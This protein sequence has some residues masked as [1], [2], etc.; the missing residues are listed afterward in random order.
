MC[1][2][3]YGGMEM[4]ELPEIRNLAGQIDGALRGAVIVGT[5][6]FQPKCLN[7]PAEEWTKLICGRK[8]LDARSRG[9]WCV[10]G[11]EGTV[12]LRL[13]L[14]MG[15][16]FLLH[17]ADEEMPEKR[18]LA[19]F[20][21]D[22]RRISV[23]FWWF[24]SLHAVAEDE[25]HSEFDRMGVD[26]LDPELDEASF[27]E[28]YAGRKAAIKTL[29]L[30]QKLICGI[31]NYY[32]HDILFRAGIHP[33]KKADMITQEEYGRLYDA[34]RYTFIRA[35]EMGGADYERD[36]FNQPGRWSERLVAYRAGE[37]CP[38]CGGII[39]QIRTGSTTGYVCAVCQ[40]Q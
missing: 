8:I 40:K 21:K 3:R 26:A 9:K 34:M 7:R 29:L 27:R 36:L 19:L 33:L 25:R 5:E 13:N 28:I 38:I 18:R 6:V 16:E 1:G 12:S 20:L 24:G 4:P 32:S 31:G 23:N 2:D 11:M 37:K 39:E 30:D 15:G 14:G 17:E 22:G 10:I 35:A